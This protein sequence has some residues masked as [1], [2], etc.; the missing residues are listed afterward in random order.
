MGHVRKQYL[1]ALKGRPELTGG[2]LDAIDPSLVVEMP[3]I[4]Y[5]QI[6]SYIQS[7]ERKADERRKSQD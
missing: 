5:E 4:Q 1:A 6:E 7:R 3:G 2:K